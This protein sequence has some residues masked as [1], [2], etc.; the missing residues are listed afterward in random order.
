MYLLFCWIIDRSFLRLSLCAAWYSLSSLPRLEL[1]LI[2]SHCIPSLFYSILYSLRTVLRR[3]PV[4]HATGARIFLHLQISRTVRGMWF[5]CALDIDE[6]R[7]HVSNSV[8]NLI[9]F[10]WILYRN[11][12]ISDPFSRLCSQPS[13]SLHYRRLHLAGWS[14]RHCASERWKRG[15][16]RETEKERN[17]CIICCNKFSTVSGDKLMRSSPEKMHF[18][19]RLRVVFHPFFSL[20][21]LIECWE[22]MMERA[23]VLMGPFVGIQNYIRFVKS[24]YL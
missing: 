13:A 9:W 19:L 15:R 12:I 10:A 7:T 4:R 2:S 5:L 20:Y 8:E 6:H 11:V 3:W 24:A 21:L 1:C 14:V 16:K 18:C 23:T 17:V 22:N